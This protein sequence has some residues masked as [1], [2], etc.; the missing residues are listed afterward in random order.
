MSY[1]TPCGRATPRWSV[2]GALLGALNVTPSLAGL[3]V[4]RAKVWVEPPLSASTPSRGSVLLIEPSVE[5]QPHV[6]PS[7]ML[8]PPSVP[9]LVSQLLLPPDPSPVVTRELLY[10][11]LTRAM[12]QVTLAA[13]ETAVRRALGQRSR[14]QTGLRERLW[15]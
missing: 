2:E 6:V 1:R 9:R 15:G 10:T 3:P 11:G 13:T 4:S 14:R 5:P 12:E 7:S 8:L